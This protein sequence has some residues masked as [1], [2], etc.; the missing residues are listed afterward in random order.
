MTTMPSSILWLIFGISLCLVEFIFPTAFV[1]VFL[2]LAA[3]S[4]AL[5]A[6]LLPLPIALQVFLW[7]MLSAGFAWISQHFLSKRSAINFS[8]T[9]AQSITA[10]APGQIGRVLYEGASWRAKSG[11]DTSHISP[12]QPLHVIDRDGTTLLVVPM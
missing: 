6:V 8:Y 5:L 4:M 1:A 12:N 2:G 7:V 9:E 11:D 10:I 3:C